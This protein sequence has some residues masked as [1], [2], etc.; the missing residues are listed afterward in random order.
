[1]KEFIKKKYNILIPV[2][3]IVVIL[4]AVFLYAREYKNN[5]YANVNDVSVY[6]YFSGKRLDYTAS[7][8]RNKKMVILNYEPKDFAISL[9]STPIYVNDKDSTSV[10]FPKEMAAFFPLKEKIYQVDALAECYINHGLTYMRLKK[11]DNA[12][13]HMFLYDGKNLYF[14]IDEVTLVV[15]DREIV[16]SPMSYVSASYLNMVEYYD[17]ANDSY[18]IIDL[19]NENAIIKNDYMTIDVTLDKV[20]YNDGLYLLS[21]DFSGYNKL[22]DMIQK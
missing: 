19:D 16:L 20:I 22:M 1:M 3:L 18:E 21:S 5:R 12:F 11:V 4:I 9:D 14:F 10:I 15:G 6:Q 2:F 8:G 13:D 7:V 17:K